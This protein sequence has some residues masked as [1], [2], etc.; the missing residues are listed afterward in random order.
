MRC[1]GRVCISAPLVVP[2]VLLLL[3]TRIISE[4]KGK[5]EVV[6]ELPELHYISN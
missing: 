5:K 2:V 3:K 1:S 6:A 4:E